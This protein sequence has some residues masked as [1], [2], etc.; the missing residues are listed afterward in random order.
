MSVTSRVLGSGVASSKE[1][2]CWLKK[3]WGTDWS[4][5]RVAGRTTKCR[6]SQT[7]CS[8]SIAAASNKVVCG[9]W[10]E[11]S[12]HYEYRFSCS[13]YWSL[14]GRSNGDSYISL[15][16]KTNINSHTHTQISSQPYKHTQD[17]QS[18]ITSNCWILLNKKNSGRFYLNAG[19]LTNRVTVSS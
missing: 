1:T 2:S 4:T 12:M 9:A 17:T 19:K 18:N 11:L 6:L 16:P 14:N 15:T 13:T 3:K 5:P 8:V 7:L 10:R